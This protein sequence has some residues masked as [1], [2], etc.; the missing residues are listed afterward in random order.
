MRIA[1]GLRVPVQLIGLTPQMV[2]CD[3]ICD[4]VFKAFGI[5]PG[6]TSNTEGKHGRKSLHYKGFARDYD[7]PDDLSPNTR[8]DLR[9]ALVLALGGA[10]SEFDVVI[11]RTHVHVEW[12][13]SGSAT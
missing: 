3:L 12:D 5:D 7:I 2:L 6:I 10:D 8:K 9:D 4:S 11:E 1:T 13:P